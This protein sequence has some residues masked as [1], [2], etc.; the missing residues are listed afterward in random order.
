[1]LPEKKKLASKG[2]E[3]FRRLTYELRYLEQTEAAIESRLNMI[4][5]VTT[6]LAYASMTLESMGKEKEDAELLVPIGASSYIKAKLD[7]S[8][9]IIVGM[10]GGVSVEKTRQEAGEIIKSRLES[11]EKTRV[12]L[13][14]QYS[15]VAQKI[16]DDRGKIEALVATLREGKIP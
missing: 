3:E 9:K 1:M 2:E 15:Q 4:N 12:A 8:D 10:G 11:L 7:S 14:Q 5:A 13:Q 6:D 16:A